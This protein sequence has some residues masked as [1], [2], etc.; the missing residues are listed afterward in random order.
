[1]TLM[2][3]FK[4]SDTN[5][6]MMSRPLRSAGSWSCLGPMGGPTYGSGKP[7]GGDFQDVRSKG[8][9]RR[10]GS[11]GRVFATGNDA[12]H[13]PHSGNPAFRRP[14]INSFALDCPPRAIHADIVK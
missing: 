6:V 1:M 3:V 12:A 11:Q 8:R 4:K 7:A 5:N 9:S 10:R 14:S 2:L 13:R